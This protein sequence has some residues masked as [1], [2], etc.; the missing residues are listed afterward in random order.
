MK[1]DASESLHQTL[2][3][4]EEQRGNIFWRSVP[5]GY[6]WEDLFYSSSA[7]EE[8]AF[9]N[10][11]ELFSLKEV[12][13]VWELNEINC[14]SGK[15]TVLEPRGRGT[16]TKFG[17]CS[18]TELTEECAHAV[19]NCIVFEIARALEFTVLTSCNCSTNLITIP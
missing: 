13:A 18:Q 2:S 5:R 11:V 15:A 4:T 14:N 3:L 1:T 10:G 6:D 19:G 16:S 17:S 8:T 7:F 12:I 9:L